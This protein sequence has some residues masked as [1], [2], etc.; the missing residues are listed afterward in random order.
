MADCVGAV[1]LASNRTTIVIPVTLGSDIRHAA[2]VTQEL[3]IIGAVNQEDEW[4]GVHLV[5]RRV[6]DKRRSDSVSACQFLPS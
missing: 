2:S 5:L 6:G 4:G 1:C 3:T